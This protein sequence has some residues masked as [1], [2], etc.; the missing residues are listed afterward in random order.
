MKSLLR[1]LRPMRFLRRKAVLAG[2]LGGNRKWLVW[3]GMAWVFHWLG[4]IFG[5]GEAKPRYTQQIGAGERVVVVH[6]PLSPLQKKKAAKKEIKQA[7]K[8]AKKA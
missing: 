6:E 1:F 8:A 2:V 5:G 4:Q 7:R 3:G